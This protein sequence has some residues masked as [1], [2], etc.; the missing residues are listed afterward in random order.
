MTNIYANYMYIF[1]SHLK[2]TSGSVETP[3]TFI[4]SF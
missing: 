3:L 1:N 4:V 2:V